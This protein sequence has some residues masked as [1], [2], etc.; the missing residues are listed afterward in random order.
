MISDHEVLDGFM[1]ALGVIV[2]LVAATLMLVMI[3]GCF[4]IG[5]LA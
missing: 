2:S 1:Y 3:L 5:P 4:G